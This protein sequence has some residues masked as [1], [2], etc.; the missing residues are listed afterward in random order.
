MSIGPLP[1]TSTS[2]AI[3]DAT[4][5]LMARYGFRKMTMEDVAQEAGVSKR[6]IYTY[7]D[8]KKD[9]GLSSIGRVV[10]N[11]HDELREIATSSGSVADRLRQILVRRV[12]GRI[13]QVQ[14]YSHSLD[15]LFAVVRADYMARRAQYFAVETALITDLLKEGCAAREIRAGELDRT[16]ESMVLATN[17]FLPYSLSVRELGTPTSIQARLTALVDLLLHGILTTKH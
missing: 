14:D 7:F 5:R 2:E 4:D 8:S 12:M 10:A 1:Q 17:A 11:V 15:E 13:E 6:T 16:A 9:L 3:L